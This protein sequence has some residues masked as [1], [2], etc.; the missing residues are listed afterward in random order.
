MKNQEVARR[1]KKFRRKHIISWKL[2]EEMLILNEI[3]EKS[4]KNHRKSLRIPV[5]DIKSRKSTLKFKKNQ[6]SQK[7]LKTSK[8]NE[9]WILAKYNQPSQIFT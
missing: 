9:I 5:N 8:F 3:Y 4:E 1:M 2:Q 7:N 6:G